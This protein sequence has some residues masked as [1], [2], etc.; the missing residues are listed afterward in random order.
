M[1]HR[2]G[3][4][5]SPPTAEGLE[6][7]L[8]LGGD[9]IAFLQVVKD[10]VIDVDGL[11]YAD[12]VAI[13]PDG[14]HVYA[15]GRDDNALAVFR[16]DVSNGR[17][18]FLE[19]L[20]D[21]VDGVDGLQ[22][23]CGVTVSP[24]GRNVYAAGYAENAVAVFSRDLATG[25]L[26]FQQV[27][28]DGEGRVDGLAGAASVTVS[29]DGRNVY[30]AGSNDKSVAVFSRSAATGALTFVQ[31]LTDGIGSID[32][33][34]GVSSV[35][36]SPDGKQVYA[37]GTSED[38]LAVFGRTAATGRLT[39]I[40]VLRDGAAGA[41]GLDGASAVTVSPD[42]KQVY[43][44]AE[45]D[46]AVTV[47][48]RA[49]TTGKLTFQQVLK[50]GVDGV[51]GLLGA[52]GLTLSRDG[53]YLYATGA[54]SNAVAL[55]TRDAATGNLTF[56]Q[57][58]VDGAASV[59]GLAGAC[60]VAA[61]PD[62]THLY[63]AGA[64]DSA[65]AALRGPNRAP[66]LDSSGV[67][68]LA[69][70]T[71]DDVNNPGTGISEILA[72]A[73]LDRITDADI[74]DSEGI[75]VIAA[76]TGHGQWQFTTSA[77]ASWASLGTPSA[78]AARLLAADANTMVRFRPAVG[79][80]GCV[81]SGLTFR[82]W[83]RSSGTNG[84]TGDASQAGGSTAFSTAVE[85]AEITVTDPLLAYRANYKDTVGG[86]VD[87]AISPDGKHLY[88][89]GKTIDSLSV[90]QRNAVTGALTI[91]QTHWNG[92]GG[93]EGLNGISSVAISADGRHVYATGYEDG[94]VTV[95]RRDA[96]TGKLT[97]LQVLRDGIG[98]VEGLA[99]AMALTVSPDPDAKNVY[100]AG[101]LGE[102]LVVFSRNPTTGGLVFLQVFMDNTDGVDGLNGINDIIISPDGRYVYAAGSEEDEVAVFARDPATGALEYFDRIKD[103]RRGVEGIAGVTSLAIS[104]D[105]KYL[106]AVGSADGA[107]AAFQ[108]D[109]KTGW[110]TFLQVL[111]NGR[112]GIDGLGDASSI[113]LSPDGS[114]VY[115]TGRTD[116]T[117][118]D[119]RRD[120]VTGRLSLQQVLKE[121]VRGVTGIAEAESVTVAPDG[122]WVYVAGSGNRAIALFLTSNSA[123][124]L[125]TSGVPIL[126][127]VDPD[128][129]NN[130]GTAVSTLIS[131]LGG[132]GVT[133]ADPWD[134][135]GLAITG[136]DNTLGHW[137]FTMNGGESWSDVGTPSDGA[138]LL[139][140]AGANTS[141]RF[142]PTGGLVEMISEA[143]QFRAWDQ[144][145]GTA[146]GTADTSVNGGSTAFSTAVAKADVG[147]FW[148]YAIGDGQAK[149]LR[150]TDGDGTSVTVTLRGGTAAIGLAGSN[151]EM[152]SGPSGLTI[153]G[154][155]LEAAGILLTGTT[156]ASSLTITT[157]KG[158]IGGATVGTIAGYSA[159]GTLSAPTVDL[160]D[161]LWIS[162][163][164]GKLALDD[165]PGPCTI[166]IGGSE[167]A[168][169][170]AAMTFDQVTD[171]RIDSAMPILS[172]AAA[173]W[174]STGAPATITAPWVGSLSVTGRRA[175]ALG[176]P[177][178]PGDFVG[179]L[180]LTSVTARQ[181]LG[182]MAVAGWLEGVVRSRGSIGAVTVGGLR[183]SRLLAGVREGE[184]VADLPG[185]AD[186]FDVLTSLG[187][188]TIKGIAGQTKWL[189]NS[190]VVAWT[191]G[192]IS[193]KGVQ[194]INASHAFGIV[195]HSLTAYTRD[196]TRAAKKVAP[197]VVDHADDYWVQLI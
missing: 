188:L 46:N 52:C 53:R 131:R 112:G 114:H 37:T 136:V 8:L 190:D 152:K 77:G 39:L 51:D 168:K 55:F 98:G 146:G 139:L 83:D 116:G 193:V 96:A 36:V 19:S 143:V 155:N 165:I 111:R 80:T 70:I 4:S 133:D 66:V 84:D 79:F 89:A 62:G 35:T 122:K 99:G 182:R 90:F 140:A 31:K 57:A 24:D 49:A 104:A 69:A 86:V 85:T 81:A 64:A 197:A 33:L 97:F 93:V 45:A 108:R 144:T 25:L 183:D 109:A 18:N 192:T 138:A 175:S 145:S 16:R 87:V 29:L 196:G 1:S 174:V 189:I 71:N 103:M 171:L 107:V 106:Y 163:T 61:A 153:T 67:M 117:L 151:L 76:D 23:V 58:L 176:L 63:V 27:L 123:P 102:A 134:L 120:P 12:S 26:A 68:A 148:N 13:S 56:K 127:W 60:S 9:Q 59:D 2:A 158:T 119:F 65:L 187:S 10:G 3:V 128:G 173:E 17:L 28:K 22:G 121:G 73:G 6:P 75:A 149:A 160:N 157:A 34:E 105:G 15:A 78:A 41:G 169:T 185:S 43:A 74:R 164:L 150:Y 194:T 88:S 7:R 72:S 11:A 129:A 186:D 118:A 47:F 92:T 101:H 54:S 110:L 50:N 48:V 162:G 124:V 135:K 38:A 181:N 184:W 167:A 82:A 91:V 125:D 32:G 191:L 132:G 137:E 14:I 20:K 126:D 159:L 179:D 44:T 42:G 141:L 147:L 94:A 178:V 40:Q 113:T 154:T 95:F 195:G 156:A 180:R 100:V 177:S 5:H 115:V 30:A 161:R 130:T 21:G 142:V 170:P 172:I 166:S